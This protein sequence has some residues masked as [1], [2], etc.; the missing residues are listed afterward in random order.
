MENT[1]LGYL[2]WEFYQNSRLLYTIWVSVYKD[3]E[4]QL[5]YEFNPIGWV[6]PEGY[7]EYTG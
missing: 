4:D 6:P 2:R 3:Y 7:L 1:F 5:I